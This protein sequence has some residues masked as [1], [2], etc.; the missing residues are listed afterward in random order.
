MKLCSNIGATI[1]SIHS[2]EQNAW[3]SGHILKQDMWIGMSGVGKGVV[4]EKWDDGTPVD[5][6][7]FK[8]G[9]PDPAK[10]DRCLQ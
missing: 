8:K 4:P 6:M 5:F 9:H 1:A 3:M 2:A 7:N 10:S